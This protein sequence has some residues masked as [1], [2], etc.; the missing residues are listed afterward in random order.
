[1]PGVIDHANIVAKLDIMQLLAADL[2]NGGYAQLPITID[3][4]AQVANGTGSGQA[5][6]VYQDSGTI[7]PS[8]TVNIDL[9]GSLAN[10]FGQTIAFTKIKFIAIRASPNNN[11]ANN[12]QVTRPAANGFSWFLAGS[13]GFY[14]A[15]GAWFL[16]YDPAGVPV[17][18]ATA[19]LLALINSAGTNTIAYDLVI[20]GTD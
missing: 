15:P 19:D 11:V 10:I 18:A 12:L 17:T 2:A 4:S 6:Q 13:D 3:W 1:M 5:S 20:V 7:G 8:A 16:W 14:L 9:A